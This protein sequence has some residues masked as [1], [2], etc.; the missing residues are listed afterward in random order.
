M[1]NET[2]MM[3]SHPDWGHSSTMTEKKYVYKEDDGKEYATKGVAGTALGLGIGALGLELLKNGNLGNILGGTDT[4]LEDTKEFHNELFGLYKSQT[5]ADFSLYKGY[6]DTNDAII[7]QHNKDAFALYSQSMNQGIALQ[8]EIDELKTKLAVQ[9][10]VRPYQ[11]KML[12][13][14]IALERE[15]RE[16]A[17]CSIVGYSN[18]TFIPQYIADITPAATSTQKLTFNPLG[19]VQGGCGCR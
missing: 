6:R 16:C 14:A 1:A 3:T 19:C 4:R 11:D 9:E 7:A 18:C 13:D 2:T 10:A 15:R 8:K 5:D 12:Y 17:D